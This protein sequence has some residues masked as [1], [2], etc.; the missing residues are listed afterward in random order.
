MKNNKVVIIGLDGGTF[1]VIHPMIEKGE[2]PNLASIMKNGSW[3]ELT[4]TI[5]PITLPAWVSFATGMNPAKHGIYYFLSDTHRTYD[6]GPIVNSTYVKAK[7]LWQILTENDKKSIVV[8]VPFTYPPI[9]VNGVMVSN[10]KAAQV[11][12]MKSYPPAVI[13]ELVDILKLN[14]LRI[15]NL[16]Q[17]IDSSNNVNDIPSRIA[18]LHKVAVGKIADGTIYLM[19]KY[20]WSFLM[21]V[22]Q[23]SDVVQHY[24]WAHM[25]KNHP[26]HKPSE[27]VK[28]GSIIFD[29][30][31][32]IDTAVGKIVEKA[33]EDAIIIIMSDHGASAVHKFFFTN[34]WLLE[35]GLLV[36]K[37]EKPFRTLIRKT[38]LER[39][40]T[41]LGLRD[42]LVFFPKKL[43]NIKVPFLKRQLKP[44]S[45]IIDWSKTKAYA[46]NTGI[47]INLNGREPNGIVSKEKYDETINFIKDELSKLI[48]T[49]T[50]EKVTDKVYRRDEIYHG[51]YLEDAYDLY[52]TPWKS[53][54]QPQK[55]LQSK[56]VVAFIPNEGRCVSGHHHNCVNGIFMIKGPDIKRGVKLDNPKIIDIMPT[57]LY[58]LGLKIPENIDGR[59]LREVINDNYLRE[60]PVNLTT[61]TEYRAQQVEAILGE[62]EEE[63]RRQLKNLGYIE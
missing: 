53:L 22:F 60:N 35:K 6:E 50:G 1:N 7:S 43:R 17:I 49:Q 41:R 3:S 56:D 45:E 16:K 47:N 46:T 63:L 10:I 58:L 27:A 32:R 28:Y 54:Y 51:P 4:S 9:E 44:L 21:T 20:N 40:L 15:E 25:D 52:F 37:E 34:R 31:K 18:A 62:E 5:P 14:E 55:S 57:V 19:D 39:V 23:S 61:T 42:V 12:K 36:L 26:N 24:F 13:G 29:T 59:V 30:Y 11:E 48:D 38:E 33:G 8:T 2:L